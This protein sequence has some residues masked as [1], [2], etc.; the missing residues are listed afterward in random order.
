MAMKDKPTLSD[1]I[2]HGNGGVVLPSNARVLRER[3]R[4]VHKEFIGAKEALCR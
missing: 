4:H 1:F 2:V 3:H